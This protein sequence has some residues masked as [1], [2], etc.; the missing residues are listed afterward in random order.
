[1]IDA[2][3]KLNDASEAS[4][5]ADDVDFAKTLVQDALNAFLEG[6]MTEILAAAKGERT[7]SRRG[8]RSGHYGRKLHMKV[9]TVEL[10]VPQDRN[11]LFSTQVFERYRR[12]EKALVS[13]LAEMYVKGVSTR[14]VSDVAERLCG[15][16]FSAATI[17]SMVAKLDESLKAFAS[18]QLEEDYV[19]LLLDARYEKVREDGSVR[20]R[21]VQIALGIDRGGKRHVL[22]VEVATRESEASWLE[23]LSRLRKRGLKGVEY[24]VS[25]AHEGLQNA[26]AKVLTTALWQRCSVHFLRNARD[27]LSRRADP[28]CLDGLKRLWDCEDLERAQEE[29]AAWRDRWGDEKGCVKLVE[30]VEENVEETLSVY[31][32]PREHRKRMKSTNMLER[33][34]EEIRRR[35]RVIRIFP[36]VE[37]CLRL[38]RALAVETHEQ[39]VT[40]KCYLTGRIGLAERAALSRTPLRKAA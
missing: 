19:Y 37:A 30:W 7:P 39:W 6:E 8:Y 22:A 34:N 1:M 40:G 23:F 26:I 15:H 16:G 36:N 38:V 29:L 20:S 35:T 11:G 14:K 10:R 24:V 31:R 3:C 17:S 4:Y 12:S 13:T 33:L 25:D 18:R 28:A 9:G 27:R 5:V 21:A 32:L 2:D